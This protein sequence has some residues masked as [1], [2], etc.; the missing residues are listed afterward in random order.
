MC[1]EVGQH[2]EEGQT[3]LETGYLGA[4]HPHKGSCPEHCLAD[5]I[6]GQWPEIEV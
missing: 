6:A 1:Q 3:V 4:S 5:L 2:R